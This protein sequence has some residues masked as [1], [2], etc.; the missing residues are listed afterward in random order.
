MT[1]VSLDFTTEEALA[2]SSWTRQAGF[3]DDIETIRNALR[4]VGA[5]PKD[6]DYFDK[7]LATAPKSRRRK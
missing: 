4:L 2:L 5:I 6:E 7:L 3:S 1:T